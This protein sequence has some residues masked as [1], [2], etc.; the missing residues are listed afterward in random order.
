MRNKLFCYAEKYTS[1]AST[2]ILGIYGKDGNKSDPWRRGRLRGAETLN[3][4]L[5]EGMSE[6]DMKPNWSLASCF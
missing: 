1:I 4:Q 2:G 5:K 6:G 3:S